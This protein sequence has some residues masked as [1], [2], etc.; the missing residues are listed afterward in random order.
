[1]SEFIVRLSEMIFLWSEIC[2]ILGIKS[3]FYS[4]IQIPQNFYSFFESS[5]STLKSTL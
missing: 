1:M 4:I 5:I 3:S 2:N